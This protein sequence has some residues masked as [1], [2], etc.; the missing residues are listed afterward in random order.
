M[1]L[2]NARISKEF[3]QSAVL[4]KMKFY[5][6]KRYKA[7]PQEDKDPKYKLE[8]EAF[9]KDFDEGHCNGISALWLYFQ[10]LQA[11]SGQA[12]KPNWVDSV[13]SLLLS[14]NED[15]FDFSRI[16]KKD[17]EDIDK[18]VNYI[19]LL[20][21]P[22]EY[23]GTSQ[24]DLVASIKALSERQDLKQEYA[25][26]SFYNIDQLTELLSAP[27]MLQNQRMMLIHSEKHA[28]ALFV[29]KN[30]EQGVQ[31]HYFD[32][33]SGEE[34]FDGNDMNKLAQAI[35]KMATGT[36]AY[37]KC[38]D[39]ELITKSKQANQAAVE[40]FKNNGSKSDI[41]RT[42]L[43]EASVYSSAIA[44]RHMCVVSLKIFS[45]ADEPELNYQEPGTVITEIQESTKFASIAQQ[46]K[47]VGVAIELASSAADSK[48]L[49]CLLKQSEEKP[50]LK[51]M[52]SIAKTGDIE[53]AKVMLDF[54]QKR[55]GN[56]VACQYIGAAFSAAFKYDHV[57]LVRFILEKLQR[58]NKEEGV[59][60]NL[61]ADKLWY[62]VDYD[63]GSLRNFTLLEDAL[64]KG[65][66][67]ILDVFF[68]Y[69][70]KSG[71]EINIEINDLDTPN[72]FKYLLHFDL[73]CSQN[74]SFL[75]S[76]K[77]I[78]SNLSL[79]FKKIDFLNTLDK[80]TRYFFLK[81]IQSFDDEIMQS[82]DRALEEKIKK[83]DQVITNGNTDII[84]KEAISLGFKL[85][86]NNAVLEKTISEN[87][88]IK[89]GIKEFIEEAK[90]IPDKKIWY[91]QQPVVEVIPDKEVNEQ[92]TQPATPSSVMRTTYKQDDFM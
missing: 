52:E 16:L 76:N 72:F 79:I 51:C 6:E 58:Y 57:E 15:N 62:I 18:L 48:S 86:S 83:F 66:F 70:L 11:Q 30:K 55:Y 26:T 23:M 69:C 37:Y 24:G 39:P 60:F 54:L 81:Y 53:S 42:L 67:D 36:G 9:F 4:K 91:K 5:L 7:T 13:V 25:V 73:Y 38:E 64:R 12:N 84:L 82:W 56:N 49:T 22:R 27:Y 21:K 41:Y 2:K 77:L 50:G 3:N 40:A 87:A 47:V 78:E 28:T 45:F 17:K 19:V 63:N 61:F 46:A 65:H 31:I 59:K 14:I 88:D 32:P 10:Y 44:K 34:V 43:S 8:I 85:K 68:T 29:T 74:M 80:Q 75:K 1:F 71:S 35:F 89:K 90:N 20:Q 33:N 92:I